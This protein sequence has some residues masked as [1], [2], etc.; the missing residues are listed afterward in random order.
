[1]RASYKKP[2]QK[3]CK[4]CEGKFQVLAP[5]LLNT[6]CPTPRYK[7]KAIR[8]RKQ[9]EKMRNAKMEDLNK[10]LANI[11]NSYNFGEVPK[12]TCI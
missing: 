12:V 2:L 8:E 11:K 9:S 5:S 1:M 7:T 10:R 3:A 6:P 4:S